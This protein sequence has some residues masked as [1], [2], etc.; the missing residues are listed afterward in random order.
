MQVNLVK[1][2]K[3]YHTAPAIARFVL[4]Y[5]RIF[6]RMDT[7]MIKD[8]YSGLPF[9]PSRSNQKFSCKENQ[10]AYNN[11]LA[12]KR[13]LAKRPFDRAL[14]TNRNILKRLLG[15]TTEVVKSRDFLA[16]AGYSFNHYCATYR[17]GDLIFQGVYDF[18]IANNGD[19][20][21]TLKPLKQ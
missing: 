9:K 7:K 1:I 8:P 15:N 11:L 13:R 17:D 5:A 19:G 14:D 6:I 18:A 12:R 21:Y 2:G 20:T 16:G 4:V 10:I 3:I